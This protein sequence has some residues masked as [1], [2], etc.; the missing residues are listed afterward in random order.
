MRPGVAD[1][2]CA[3]TSRALG[4]GV[5]QLRERLRELE[6]ELEDADEPP[7]D[8]DHVLRLPVEPLEVAGVEE[9]CGVRGAWKEARG[10]QEEEGL[11]RCAR[12]CL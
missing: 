8:L 9:G 2:A 12:A 4:V 10:Q 7:H 5:V 1:F 6:H 3:L 11:R